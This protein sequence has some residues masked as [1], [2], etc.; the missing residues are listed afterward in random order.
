[1]SLYRKYRP[2]SFGDVSGQDAAVQTLVNA[3]KQ[4]R[5][6]HA[7]LFAGTRGTGKTSIAR[8]LA[9]HILTR[10][11]EDEKIRS[12]V[13]RAVEEGSLVDLLEIDAAS[14]RGIDDVR[15]LLE[16]IHFS[17][18]VSAAKVFII[19]EAHML[20]KEAFNA[21]LKTL[22]EPPSY[23]YFILA[24]T[25]MHKIPATILSRCQ[26]FPF[27]QISEE[28]IVRRLQYIADCEHITIDRAAVR[29]IAM[30]AGGS[31]RD[32]IG[33]LDQLQSFAAITPE[34]VAEK[35]GSIGP[36]YLDKLLAALETHDAEQVIALVR[37]LEQEG[38]LFEHITRLLLT[39]FR[40][41]LHR[42]VAAKGDEGPALRTID[43]LLDC[44]KH[45]RNAPLPGI[46]FESALLQMTK[47]GPTPPV[48]V[49]PT[50]KEAPMTVPKPDPLSTTAAATS[51]HHA[52][53]APS[54]EHKQQKTPTIVSAHTCTIDEL[55]TVWHTLVESMQPASAKMAMRNGRLREIEGDKVTVVFASSFDREKASAP[56]GMRSLEEAL[57]AH[58][59]H[60]LRIECVLE[61]DAAPL[62]RGEDINVAEAAQEIF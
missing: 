11:V 29:M 54:T 34:Q 25:E 45:L 47:E 52:A 31:L 30:N 61:T 43:R 5:I 13:M 46:V 4:D 8:I 59:K 37:E 9:K 53:S 55:R 60:L 32:A 58:A 48:L 1:M 7:Y 33:L 15:S 10:G 12:Y 38:A 22:E 39:K 19:D 6:A 20:T 14:N 51:Q 36:L 44:M 16:K 27:R 28:D 21:L 50:T 62:P 42:Q 40:E 41:E 57:Q 23:A 26:R 3:V 17:P 24:T 18:S 2:Q 56:A 35:I 49:Q